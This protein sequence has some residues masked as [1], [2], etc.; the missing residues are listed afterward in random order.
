MNVVESKVKV[1][2]L[3][4]MNRLQPSRYFRHLSVPPDILQELAE[5]HHDP[6]LW[7]IGQVE[8]YIF[9]PN[10][11]VQKF[12]EDRTKLLHF[13][14]PIVGVHIRRSDKIKEAS[15]QSLFSYIRHVR[16]FYDR[17]FTNKNLTRKVFLATDTPKMLFKAR[18]KYLD[19]EFLGDVEVSRSAGR[20]STRHSDVALRDVITDLHLLSRS[21]FLVCTFSSNMCRA[22]YEMMQAAADGDASRRVKSLDKPLYW[23]L[24]RLFRKKKKILEYKYL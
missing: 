12:I 11:A 3:P 10:P 8:S 20:M 19:L 23:D 22:A 1:I 2:H 13:G 7:W 6:Q 15:Y 24:D 9:R 17:Q 4:K 14:S 18:R 21:D 16:E 5:V